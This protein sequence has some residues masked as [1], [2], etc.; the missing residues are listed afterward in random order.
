[1]ALS[2]AAEAT[3][4]IDPQ[5]LARIRGEE[6]V[7][8]RQ[9]HPAAQRAFHQAEKTMP[10]GVPL[11]WMSQWGTPY[12][13]YAQA[14]HGARLR[15][16][17]GHEYIDFCLG[18]SAA[19]YG[20]GHPVVM[21]AIARDLTE[22]GTSYML[23]TE[24]SIAV[25]ED[26]SRR[27]GLP[28]WQ[29][30]TS[31][32]DANRFALRVARQMTGRDKVLVFNGKYHG[33]VDD[34][35]VE[36]QNGR[37]APQHGIASNGLDYDRTTRVVEFNDV[38][39]LEEALSH[40]DVAAVLAEPHM[41]NIGMIPAAEGFHK[42]LREITRKTGTLLIIDE[43][44]TICLGPSGG[45]GE[46]GLEPDILVL[47][48]VLSGGIPS[49]VWG[50]NEAVGAFIKDLTRGPGINHYGFGGTLVANALTLR[51][52]RATLSHVITPETYAGTTEIAA[53]LEIQIRELIAK[54]NLPWH[55]SRMGCRVEYLY[56]PDVPRNGGEAAM[57]R[58]D[59]IELLS[60]LYF[61]N[62]GILLTPFHNM[63]LISPAT[64]I[65]D[66]RAHGAV[67]DEMLTAFTA[68]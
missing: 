55:V 23:P 33:S 24:D 64:T 11:H 17:D 5:R 20:H 59:D 63:A 45:T 2:A 19:L 41:T 53:A 26:L 22:L 32:T 1:M 16:I 29:L 66:V 58:N 49:A 65:E 56:M 35:Q 68:G 10:H 6:E 37:I 34:T 38:A 62:R 52:M 39:A 21:D 47:G 18:D 7:R 42:A 14:A 36:L 13:I 67:F 4:S 28:Y 40:G 30:A 46:L 61:A 51:A 54:H 44:H 12:P 15:D 31:A 48:K 8:F 57:A 50:M 43:T 25:T 3:H 60:H 27:F 9:S